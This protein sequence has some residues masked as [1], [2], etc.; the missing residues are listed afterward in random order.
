MTNLQLINLLAVLAPNDEVEVK[1][2]GG[3]NEDFTGEINSASLRAEH[4]AF[5]QVCLKLYLTD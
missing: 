2:D 1:Y 5:D 4:N 3:R